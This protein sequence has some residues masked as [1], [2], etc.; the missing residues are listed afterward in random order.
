MNKKQM[1][2]ISLLLFGMI[3]SPQAYAQTF[4]FRTKDAVKQLTPEIVQKNPMAI[5]FAPAEQSDSKEEILALLDS[6]PKI[7]GYLPKKWQE[8]QDVVADSVVH[9]KG[10]LRDIRELTIDTFLPSTLVEETEQP[11]AEGRL[12]TSNFSNDHD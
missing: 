2:S 3:C 12:A 9:N 6:N 1:S 10:A 8:D 7:F 11:V 5:L 4:D